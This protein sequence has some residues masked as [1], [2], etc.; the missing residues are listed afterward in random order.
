MSETRAIFQA[1]KRE[2]KMQGKTYA[3]LA[4][5]LDIS[6]A[7]V[8]RLFSDENITLDRL[9]QVCGFLQMTLAELMQ[10]VENT[11]P[12]ISSLT[13]AQE[14]ELIRDM[15]LLLVAVCAMNH[16]RIEDIVAAYQFTEAE[17]LQKLLQLDKMG[18]LYLLPNN[19]IRLNLGRDFAWQPNGPIQQFWFASGIQ[20]YFTTP[21]RQD[22]G[23]VVGHAMLS[24]DQMALMMTEMQRL[25]RKLSQAHEACVPLTRE[26]KAGVVL[27]S[28]LKHWEPQQFRQLRRAPPEAAPEAP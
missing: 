3:H 27:V 5:E 24:D 17:V 26:H 9:A 8:K 6:E 25:L 19:R 7:S 21:M 14:N 23:I 13:R 11:E 20:D 1:I 16:W 15:R 28:M 18:F 12:Q 4:A 10:R 2:L 22:D